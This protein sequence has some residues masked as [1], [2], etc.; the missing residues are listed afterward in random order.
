MTVGTLPDVL[1]GICLA[2]P[3]DRIQ[4]D[5]ELRFGFLRAQAVSLQLFDSFSLDGDI[6]CIWHGT[7]TH[8]TNLA[9]PEDAATAPN[10]PQNVVAQPY[11]SMRRQSSFGV[12]VKGAPR[13]HKTAARGRRPHSIGT[14]L[15]EADQEVI[16]REPNKKREKIAIEG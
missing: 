5:S 15:W 3:H 7:I 1:Y 2:A 14:T 8:I 4:H 6:E 10:R 9:S 16:C 11:R 12:Q 13:S